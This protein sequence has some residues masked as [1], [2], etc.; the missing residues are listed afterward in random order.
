ME[1]ETEVH[2][3]K[4]RVPKS[5]ECRLCYLAQALLLEREVLSSFM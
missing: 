4:D 3:R 5:T 2:A 1:F